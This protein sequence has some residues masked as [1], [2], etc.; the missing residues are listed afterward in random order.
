[1][2][3]WFARRLKDAQKEEKGFTLIEL[4]VVIL[5]I[6]ILAAIAIPVFLAQRERAWEAAA[7]SDVRNAAAAATTCYTAQA[8]AVQTYTTC[9]TA[10]D[11]DDFGYN[12][13][14][15]VNVA[16]DSNDTGW[17]MGAQ[18]ASG[19]RQAQFTTLAGGAIARGQVVLVARGAAGPAAPA[20][21]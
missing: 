17:S 7:Q 8:G 2:L 9:G 16:V 15:A 19:G 11:L 18:H 6:G 14:T 21:P 13:T 10:T 3:R 4:L 1:M 12:Q 20:I 5:I